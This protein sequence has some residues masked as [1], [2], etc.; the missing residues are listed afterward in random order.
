MMKAYGQSKLAIVYFTL[1][2]ARRLAGAAGRA[3]GAEGGLG[4]SSLRSAVDG[5]GRWVTVNAVDPGP[6]ASNIGADNPGLAYRLVGPLIRGFFPSAARA[7]RTAVRV[8][9]DPALERSTGGYW[10]SNKRRE[11]PLDFDP[12]LSR[13]L[14]EKSLALAGIEEPRLG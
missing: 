11:K 3:D 9:T 6:V 1:E 14:W 7:A 12:A 8:A 2:L 10:R 5:S 4:A 13:A